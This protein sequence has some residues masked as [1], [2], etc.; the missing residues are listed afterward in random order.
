MNRGFSKS[1]GFFLIFFKIA[2]MR[3][4]DPHL[5]PLKEKKN[6]APPPGYVGGGTQDASEL[7]GEDDDVEGRLED[8]G[9]RV[10]EGGRGGAEAN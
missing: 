4:R 1:V 6:N 8:G 5:L 9:E 7:A 2:R 3:E 10:R